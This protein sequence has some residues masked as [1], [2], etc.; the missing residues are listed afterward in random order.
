VNVAVPL[1]ELAVEIARLHG[2]SQTGVITVVPVIVDD[3]QTARPI[4]RA[5]C[6]LLQG[7]LL[8]A[9]DPDSTES[10]LQSP[11]P[12][13]ED[14]VR[15]AAVTTELTTPMGRQVVL[16]NTAGGFVDA[17]LDNPPV[18]KEQSA[19]ERTIVALA[20]AT[21]HRDLDQYE[22]AVIAYD[23]GTMDLPFRRAVWQLMVNQLAGMRN[24]TLRTLVVVAE[25]AIDIELHCQTDKG[26]RFAVVG[27]RFLR[28]QGKDNLMATVSSISRHPRPFVLFLGAGFAA[29]S[30]LPLGNSVRDSAI[31]RLLSI[32]AVESPTSEDLA[33]RFHAFLSEKPGWFSESEQ[34]MSREEFVRKLTLE[35]V[36]RA[37]ARMDPTIPT[38]E[39]FRQHHDSVIHSPGAAALDL[40]RI[41]SNGAGRVILIEVNFDLLVEQH[42][43]VPLRVF[44]SDEEFV[45]AAQ[46]LDRYL[47]REESAIPLLKLHGTITDFKTC[48][49]SE[50][51]TEQGIGAGK[52]AAL[53]KLL[54][55]ANLPRLWIYVGVS[56][57]DRDLLRVLVGE[58]FAQGLDE[59]WV[60]PYLVD[61]VAD[62]AHDRTP[63][64]ARTPQLNIE[65]RLI[66]ETADAF[67]SSLNSVWGSALSVR[68]A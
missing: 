43:Q 2:Q 11:V 5:L 46:Y 60:C 54:G 7:R 9:S 8:D 67:F 62:Y 49:V 39:E 40:A 6:D 37:E 48:V 34:Q 16:K 38:L 45:S 29:S 10:N 52:L 3:L 20:R 23:S 4:L 22:F 30:R 18:G 47:A 21:T 42:A 27:G 35:R 65:D 14:P 15:R 57:R 55:P 26:F 33:I 1:F 68:R 28:R 59:R 31:K 32:P 51:Q 63:F 19:G 17:E 24:R 66:T 56:M 64:W 12:A 13:T 25:A 36:V 44:A 61:T 53:R 41:L 50:E 58:E